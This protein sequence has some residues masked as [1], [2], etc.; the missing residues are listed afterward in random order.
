MNS[1]RGLQGC[2]QWANLRF[3]G[4]FPGEMLL[5]IHR[6]YAAELARVRLLIDARNIR[7]K[8][9]EQSEVCLLAV[10]VVAFRVEVEALRRK[11]AFLKDFLR[12]PRRS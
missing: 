4:S 9:R 8:R 10:A 3:I 11:A 7:C 5:A 1:R 2:K 12:C 6:N